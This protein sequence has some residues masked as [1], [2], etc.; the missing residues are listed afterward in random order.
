MVATQTKALVIDVIKVNLSRQVRAAPL[1]V[2]TV[3]VLN[4]FLVPSSKIFVSHTNGIHLVQY[5]WSWWLMEVRVV[6]RR[7][8]ALY[9]SDLW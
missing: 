9:G 4:S 3:T 6:R 8:I 2:I 1:G 5:Q 7:Q